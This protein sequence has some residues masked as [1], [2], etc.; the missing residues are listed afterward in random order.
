[1]SLRE[2]QVGRNKKQQGDGCN[3]NMEVLPS[4]QGMFF[5]NNGDFF[6]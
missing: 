3:N 6:S 4:D 1:M 5:K 2:K